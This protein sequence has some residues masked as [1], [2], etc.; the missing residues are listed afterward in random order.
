MGVDVLDIL[1]TILGVWFTLRKL[2]AQSRKPEAFGHVAPG[3]FLAWQEREVGAYRTAV[4]ACFGKVTVDLAFTYLVAP[5]QSAGLVRAV[6][7]SIDLT[8]FA[9]LVVTFFRTHLAR[10]QRR[11]LGIVLGGRPIARAEHEADDDEEGRS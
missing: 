4:W 7:A 5:G 2:D 1:A 9:L 10:K 6:G 8:W 3:D 11:E